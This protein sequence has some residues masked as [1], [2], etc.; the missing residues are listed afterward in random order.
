MNDT[1]LKE[2]VKLLEARCRELQR[3]CEEHHIDWEARIGKL[4]YL[5]LRFPHI[6]TRLR[7][8]ANDPEQIAA[9]VN[10]LIYDTR[11]D[12]EG[13][14]PQVLDELLTLALRLKKE[15]VLNAPPLQGP[16]KPA[17]ATSGAAWSPPLESKAFTGWD[18]HSR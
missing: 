10:E 2:R 17:S 4:S 16:G 13:F 5:E 12:A 7:T 9:Y 1:D 14:P 18:I 8:L 3:L 15:N 6:A 11:P